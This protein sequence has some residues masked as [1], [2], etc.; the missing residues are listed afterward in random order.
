M[1]LTNI[2]VQLS[3]LFEKILT[4]PLPSQPILVASLLC[5]T[6]EVIFVLLEQH[7]K[8]SLEMLAPQ[9]LPDGLRK[10]TGFGKRF[11][12]CGSQ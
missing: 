1:S 6:H 7:G 10:V 3:Q 8:A 12:K 9:Y 5:W 2:Q 11:L 4:N